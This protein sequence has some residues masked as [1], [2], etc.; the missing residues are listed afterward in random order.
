M[1]FVKHFEQFGCFLRGRN[2]YFISL[3]PKVKYILTFV[4]FRQISLIG[5]V[6]KIIAT[7][8]A[9]RNMR[10]I[11]LVIDEIQTIFIKGKNILDG[12]MIINEVCAWA[13]KSKCKSFLFKVDFDK[14]FDSTNQNYLDST[15]LPMRFGDKWRLWIRG[16]LRS[17][18]ASVIINGSATKEFPFTKGVRQGDPLSPFLFIITMEGLNV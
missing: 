17:S 7:T 6:Y 10:V 2:S 9:S 4:D 8:L 15:M 14:A 18:R 13:I 12:P 11:G 1:R 5:C 16:C 3:L